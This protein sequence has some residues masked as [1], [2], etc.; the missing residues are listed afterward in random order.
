MRVQSKF[1]QLM[2]TKKIVLRVREVDRKIFDDVKSGKKTVETRAATTKFC[3]IQPGDILV[4]VCGKDKF[5]K[6]IV[7]VEIFQTIPKMLQKYKVEN[8][9]PDA[10]SEEDLIKMYSSFPGYEEKI[11]KFGLVALLIR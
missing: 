6:E 10:S 7:C 5:E 11:K 3:R 2:E 8:I 9:M 1:I 4:M